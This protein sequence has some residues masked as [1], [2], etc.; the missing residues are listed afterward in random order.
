MNNRKRNK[1]SYSKAISWL[2]YG[3]FALFISAFVLG[4]SWL[5]ALLDP[6]S[7]YGRMVQNLFSPL[8]IWGNNALAFLAERADSYRFYTVDVWIKSVSTFVVA[9]ITLVGIVIFSYRNGLTYCNK[10]CPV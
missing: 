1:Y 10:I 8:Y 5:V 2:R 9:A 7:A 6:Y 4:I 3:V